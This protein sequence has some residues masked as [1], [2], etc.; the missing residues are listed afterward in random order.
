MQA[1]VAV[2]RRRLVDENGDSLL[3]GLGRY[4]LELAWVLSNFE[5]VKT[6]KAGALL[7]AGLED[8]KTE[9]TRM[10]R[11]FASPG[12]GTSRMRAVALLRSV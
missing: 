6:G 9:I 10:Q 2:K 1:A 5:Q 12:G 7:A 11:A 8:L 4:L 3:A